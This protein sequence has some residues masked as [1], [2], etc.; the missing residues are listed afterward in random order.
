MFHPAKKNMDSP[1]GL[2]HK[3]QPHTTFCSFYF[4][5]SLM[6]NITIPYTQYSKSGPNEIVPITVILFPVLYHPVQTEI[7]KMNLTCFLKIFTYLRGKET[8]ILLICG[9]IP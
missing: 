9:I 2:Q 1:F 8:E 6:L 5:L 4:S 7:F 3:V